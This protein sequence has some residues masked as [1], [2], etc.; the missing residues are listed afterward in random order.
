MTMG[1][2]RAPLAGSCNYHTNGLISG[3]MS[4]FLDSFYLFLLPRALLSNWLGLLVTVRR[5]IWVVERPPP[6]QFDVSIF[7][8]AHF[9]ESF[10]RNGADREKERKRVLLSFFNERISCGFP[11]HQKIFCENHSAAAVFARVL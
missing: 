3:V 10:T 5:G 11:A 7:V 4:T 6:F 2:L 1:A 9:F 8:C